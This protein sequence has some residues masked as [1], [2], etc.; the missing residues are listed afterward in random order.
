[1]YNEPNDHVGQGPRD[2]GW[3]ESDGSL[4]RAKT[5]YFLEKEVLVLFE[6]IEG[7]PDEEDI[8]ADAG[9]NLVFPQRVWD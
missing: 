1:M 3:E 5:L 9:E 4:Q 2:R 6:N 7:S 8:D